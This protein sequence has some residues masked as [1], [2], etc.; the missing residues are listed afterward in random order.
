M[1][2][3]TP[4]SGASFA[5][6]LI[7][8]LTR[9]GVAETSS[10]GSDAASS[11]PWRS[12][13]VPRRA[14]SVQRADLLAGRGAGQARA[15]DGAEEDRAA[16]GEEQEDEERGEQQAD[17]AL[18]QRHRLTLALWSACAARDGG[19]SRRGWRCVVVA[20]G[21]CGCAVLVVAGAVVVVA[22]AALAVAGAAL[23]VAAAAVAVAGAAVLVTGAVVVAAGAVLVGAGAATV[24]LTGSGGLIAAAARAASAPRPSR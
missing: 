14:G 7:G 12:T 10:A 9:Y 17:A 20:S 4:S 19:R 5:A 21:R 1:S 23:V 3:S 8:S 2:A 18:E 22:G 13:I 16:R 6:V 11:K 15:L 24:G